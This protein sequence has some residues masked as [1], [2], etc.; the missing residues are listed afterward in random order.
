[1]L[2][3]VQTPFTILGY[4]GLA[5]LLFLAAAGGGFWMAWTILAGDVRTRRKVSDR[6]PTPMSNAQ[7]RRGAWELELDIGSSLRPVLCR[8]VLGIDHHQLRMR[9]LVGLDDRFGSGHGIGITGTIDRIRLDEASSGWPAWS[10]VRRKSPRPDRPARRRRSRCIP[11]DGCRASPRSRT[12][13]RP[14]AGELNR[15]RKSAPGDV[16]SDVVHEKPDAPAALAQVPETESA[17]VALDPTES[18]RWS[19]AS[20]ISKARAASIA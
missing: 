1:M 7:V 20:T 15:P 9:R 12:P 16:V 8:P 6:L 2:M 17:L 4:P 5:M 19:V 10:R 13:V 11:R 3:R 18:C 14:C